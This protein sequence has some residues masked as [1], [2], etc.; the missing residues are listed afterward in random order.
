ALRRACGAEPRGRLG[1]AGQGEG[2]PAGRAVPLG[3]PEEPGAAAVRAKWLRAC[4][5]HRWGGQHG[6]RAGRALPLVR[7]ARLK[8][9][10]T[11]GSQS[12]RICARRA[13]TLT[14][15]GGW[16]FFP[17]R[18]GPRARVLTSCSALCECALLE[19]EN[20]ARDHEPL[21]LARPL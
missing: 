2:A 20:R 10:A 17:S 18:V 16:N 1:A 12:A 14:A 3:V 4:A 13:V 5:A 8:R 21:D 9:E 7:P 19:A 15:G 6:A 11:L